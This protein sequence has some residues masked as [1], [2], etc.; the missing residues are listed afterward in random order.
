MSIEVTATGV[1]ITV[2]ASGTKIE[3]T[4]SGGVGPQGASGVMYATAPLVYDATT[5]TVSLAIGSGLTTSGGAIVL[6]THAHAI[7]D[8]T[9]LEAALASKAT[10]ADVA[11]AVAGVIDAA[12]GALD[13]L[14]ELAAAL[15]D[16]A[17][18][19][20]TVTTALAGK[21]S[22]S[23]S[24]LS[25][26][27]EWSADTISQ[28]EAEDGSSTTRRAFTAARVFQA[29]AAW[30]AGSAAKTKLDGIEAGATANATNAQLR[31]RSTHTGTQEISTVSGLQTALD[32]KAAAA[33]GHPISDVTGLQDEL[34]G[35]QAAGSYAAATHGHAIADVTGL[36]ASLDGKAAA[37]HAHGNITTDG[38]IGTASGQIVVTTTDGALI[39]VPTISYLSVTGLSSVALSGLYSDLIGAPAAYSL[40]TA[41]ASVLGGVKVGSGLSI[42]SGTLSATV[43]GESFHPFLL[44]GM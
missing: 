32:G 10:P 41:S 33:H 44:A 2:S 11:T 20:S 26:A 23:D 8:V 5:K 15:G 3:A 19:A 31:D 37:S 34:D 1:P 39:A 40:P 6:G 38:A 14:N 21:V 28:A 17:N 12:P 18:F 25:D 24:R 29:V 13:T 42:S 43:S 7:T 36:Q 4:V 9:G 35:K 16:D 22:T 30:W 27:R